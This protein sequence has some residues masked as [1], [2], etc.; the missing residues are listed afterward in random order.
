MPGKLFVVGDPKQSIYRFRRADVGIYESVREQLRSHGAACVA[1][2]SSF[3]AVPDIQRAVNAAFAADDRRRGGRP[4]VGVPL[5]PVRP[6]Q[7]GQ[8][9]I[10]ALPVPKVKLWNG[11][12]TK[13]SLAEGQPHAVAAFV[14]WLVRSSGWTVTDRERPTE[15]APIQAR[16]V[17]LLFR[18]FDTR[19]FDGPTIDVTRPYV[20]ALEARGLP[21][22]L[23]GGKSF[24]E[25][26]EVETLRTALAAIEWPDDELSVFDAPRR[27]VRVRRRR[28]AGLPR[29]RQVLPPVSRTE[30]P[31][32]S[33]ARLPETRRRRSR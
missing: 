19:T 5:A 17:C 29:P 30:A 9:A 32:T 16:D 18:R 10:V 22:L 25:R 12:P 31:G 1:L 23:V 15:R 13:A 33:P 21:H 6:A 11:V 7:R 8:P 14:D 27:A 28:P 26:E 24:H 3:R 20:Q 2:R 4:G